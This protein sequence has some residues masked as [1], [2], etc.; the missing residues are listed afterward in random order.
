MKKKI[1]QDRHQEA[2]EIIVKIL[3]KRVGAI[4]GMK[5]IV[6]LRSIKK[7]KIWRKKKKMRDIIT[8]IKND[9]KLKPILFTFY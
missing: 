2:L 6:T 4:P 3:G 7:K 8:T 1:L 9:T 5:V